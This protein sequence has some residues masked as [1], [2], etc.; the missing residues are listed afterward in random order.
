MIACGICHSD[1]SVL[2]NDWGNARYPLVPGHEAVGK[3]REVGENVAHLK[4]GQTVGLG[5]YSA[6]CLICDQCMSGDHNLCNSN[7]STILGRPGGNFR[8]FALLRI[9]IDT[10]MV[11]GHDLPVEIGI[12]NLVFSEIILGAGRS[13]QPSRTAKPGRPFGNARRTTG[14]T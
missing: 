3:I 7:E 12:L 9:E 14:P 5:W 2:D 13:G 4:V 1:L 11:G 6:S 8:Q 10:K